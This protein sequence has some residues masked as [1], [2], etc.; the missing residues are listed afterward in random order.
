[1]NRKKI[2]CQKGTRETACSAPSCTSH[3]V[4]PVVFLWFG[5]HAYVATVCQLAGCMPSISPPLGADREK[6]YVGV[7]FSPQL[8]LL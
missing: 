2:A 7:S 4:F 1:M 6:V 3:L 5:K 8:L